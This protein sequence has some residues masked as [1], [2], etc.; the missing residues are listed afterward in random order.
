MWKWTYPYLEVLV[1]QVGKKNENL[2]KP[3][4]AEVQKAELLIFSSNDSAE[5][6]KRSFR[7]LKSPSRAELMCRSWTSYRWQARQDGSAEAEFHILR[8]IGRAEVLNG[9]HVTSLVVRPNGSAGGRISDLW[10][11]SSWKCGSRTLHLWQ[12]LILLIANAS[13]DE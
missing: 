12:V 9:F 5:L 2:S 7:P 13:V 1:E 6:W 4:R 3:G 10:Q 8:R 11:L